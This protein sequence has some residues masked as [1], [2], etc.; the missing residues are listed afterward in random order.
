MINKTATEE[1]KYNRRNLI[2]IWLDYKKAF[3][4]VPHDWI[5]ESLKLAK[6]P[7]TVIEAIQRLIGAWKTKVFLDK[8]NEKIETDEIK[9]LNGI[10]QGDLLS[11]ILFILSV[12]PLSFLLQKNEGYTLGT[13][14]NRDTKLNHLFFVDDLKLYAKNLYIAKQL[15]EV[16]TT[17]SKDINMQFGVEK[18]AYIYIE[19]GK[20]KSLGETI[21]IHDDPIKELKEDETYKYLGQ[22]EAIGYDGPINKD[23]VLKEY[24]RRV[25][26]IWNSQLSALNK[27]IAH[28]VFAVPIITPTIGVLDWNRN[29]I[30]NLDIR[31]RKTMAMSGSLHVRSDVERLYAKRAQGGRG[32]ISINDVYTSRTIALASHIKRSIHT[33]KLLNKVYEHEQNN[34][35]RIAAELKESL[36]L[37]DENQTMKQLSQRVKTQLKEDHFKNWQTKVTHGYNQS[38]IRKNPDIDNTLSNTWLTKSNLSSHIEGY[39]FAIDEQEVATKETIKRREKDPAKRRQIDSKCRLCRK[40][41]E[42]LK[43]ILAA[44]SEVSSSLH[45]SYRHDRMGK[46]V[47]EKLLQAEGEKKS[48]IKIPQVTKIGSKELWWDKTIILPNKVN[49]NRPDL[50]IWNNKTKECKIIDFSVPLDQNISMKETEKVNNYIPLV[51]E[52]QQLYRTYTYEVIPIVIGTLGAIPKSL[53]RNLENVGLKKDMNDT[54][55]RMQVAVLKGTAKTVKTVLRMK[56]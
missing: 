38:L 40:N 33:N 50:V 31:T 52:L 19:R 12:N 13:S 9:Y 26:K 17:F 6:V 48:P 3:D 5:I 54:I 39:L 28:N 7:H 45:L 42:T 41:D 29:E 15:L 32:L 30:D 25:K 8:G 23:R 43:H 20:R 21:S 16:V 56:K 49:H 51:S 44:C 47:Y 53:K 34:F 46:V 10:L 37:I 2:C 4:S 22:D 14:L 11:L 24:L 18:C 36:N 35:V 55:R 1:C 27:T